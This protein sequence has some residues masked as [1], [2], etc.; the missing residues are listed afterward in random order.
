MRSVTCRARGLARLAPIA[1]LSSRRQ[2]KPREGAAFPA[3]GFKLARMVVRLAC[4]RR[5]NPPRSCAQEHASDDRGAPLSPQ[6]PGPDPASDLPL[7]R[8]RAGFLP[9]QPHF[10]HVRGF[11]MRRT[12]FDEPRQWSSLPL[13]GA[14]A[15]HPF[16][17]I[18]PCLRSLGCTASIAAARSARKASSTFSALRNVASV[19]P[20]SKRASITR[21]P[22]TP[23]RGNASNAG[24]NLC[25]RAT[26]KSSVPLIAASLFIVI[27]TKRQ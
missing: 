17:E 18:R 27:N 3:C 13:D 6:S 20:P 24:M 8:I 14:R 9:K 4:A 15:A 12:H 16:L 19:T 22:R 23:R 26:G 11:R 2:W 7:D 1:R 25:R 5:R 10:P 21:P